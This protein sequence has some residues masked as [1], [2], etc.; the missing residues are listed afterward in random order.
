MGQIFLKEFDE[1][2]LSPAV[3]LMCCAVSVLLSKCH[4][5]LIQCYSSRLS[6]AYKSGNMV[7]IKMYNLLE[8]L[9]AITIT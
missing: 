9:S 5:L 7:H 3:S 1:L 2:T 6:A 8:K 4:A